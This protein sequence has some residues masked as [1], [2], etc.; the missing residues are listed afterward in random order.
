MRRSSG[1]TLLRHRFFDR[2]LTNSAIDC[3]LIIC[4]FAVS[5][6]V[7]LALGLRPDIEHLSDHWQYIDLGLL[8]DDYLTSLA[9]LHS[10]PPLWNAILGLLL[11]VSSGSLDTFSLWFISFSAILSLAI[12]FAIYFTLKRLAIHRGLALAAST[13]YILASSS[14]FYENIIFYPLFTA[15]L[16]I[17]FF[18]AVAFAFSA[19]KLST[20]YV[21]SLLACF[22]LICLSL[23]WSLFHPY[24]VI[25][26]SFLILARAY[27]V[28]RVEISSSGLH[29]ARVACILAGLLI[30]LMT[31]AVPIKNMI[32]FGNFGNGSWMGMNLAQVSP[33]RLKQ[34]DFDAPLTI[35][36][37]ESSKKLT[38]FTSSASERPIL[39][40]KRKN[41]GQYPNLNHI[42]Y[43]S[44]S[45]TCA[46]LA[47][48]SIVDNIPAYALGSANR[49]LRSHRRLSDSFLAF[50]IGM[51]DDNPIQK[52]ANFRN[53]LF[54]PI[55]NP[56]GNRHI[57]PL[58]IPIASLVGATL[59]VFFPNF[60]NSLPA[61]VLEV[62]LAGFWMML[63]LYAV[64]HLFNGGEQE[65]MRFTIEPI[66]IGWLTILLQSVF[67]FFRRKV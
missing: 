64:G 11:I 10:Q 55:S 34:C 43:I 44:R 62:I 33:D 63:W 13:V 9:L 8:Q 6:I 37:I 3:L 56:N 54:L 28:W 45:N 47:T 66:F 30:T 23:T 41:S 39:F 7:L 52:I 32:L 5:R 1:L 65:R 50:P 46:T 12:A 21:Y 35:E 25:L 19:N 31:L 18:S 42:G 38:S 20:A 24:I 57:A 26:T 36:E 51:G 17:C 67:V 40:S 53:T 2:F 14:Y 15:F 22:S 16:A 59:L 4:L 27:K 60:R 49:F 29:N 61:G 58:S 48:Q